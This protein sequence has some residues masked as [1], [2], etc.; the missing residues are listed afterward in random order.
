MFDWKIKA[1]C[2]KMHANVG[3]LAEKTKVENEAETKFCSH[4]SLAK[5]E[6]CQIKSNFDK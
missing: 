2:T 5:Y 6:V 1:T 3:N 4:V